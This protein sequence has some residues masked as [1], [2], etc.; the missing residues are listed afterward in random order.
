MPIK[1]QWGD[2]QQNT[3]HTLFS[4]PFDLNDWYEAITKTCIMLNT[5][6]HPVNIILDMSSF[7]HLPMT[8]IN[9]LNSSKP[10][11]HNNQEAQILVVQK[12][13][14][15]PAKILINEADMLRGTAVASSLTNAYQ[16]LDETQV[17]A[18]VG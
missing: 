2:P 15:N 12:S 18:K 10:R 1:I 4:T 3:I 16:M 5:V 11:L 17:F 8:L 6:H 7:D 13:L 14:L 9:A